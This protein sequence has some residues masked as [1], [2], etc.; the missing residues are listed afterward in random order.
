M[1]RLAAV[2]AVS[3]AVT[4]G[5]VAFL[6]TT[7]T[8]GP[9]FTNNF[10]LTSRVTSYEVGYAKDRAQA[11]AFNYSPGD[12]VVIR[13]ELTRGAEVVGT[14]HTQCTATYPEYLL[15]TNVGVYPGEGTLSGTALV[16]LGPT[17]PDPFDVTVTG[18]T[19]SFANKRGYFHQVESVPFGTTD[20]HLV[21]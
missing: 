7:A 8:A 4:G 17:G 18:G 21:G 14:G 11:L 9:E 10:S 2:L 16:H 20:Y 19:G 15:C 3:V 13:H 6:P 1:R 5:V 12:T